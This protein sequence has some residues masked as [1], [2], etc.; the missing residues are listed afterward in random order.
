MTKANGMLARIDERTKNTQE[1]IKEIK[2]NI[3]EI[4]NTTKNHR[5]DL[6]N[7]NGRIKTIERE[8]DSP[9]HKLMRLVGLF[10]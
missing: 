8:R 1:D 7:H 2:D 9:F 3:K 6:E 5:V 4:F 10:K